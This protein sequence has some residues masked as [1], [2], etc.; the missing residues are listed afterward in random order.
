MNVKQ[1]PLRKPFSTVELT[2]GAG[3]CFSTAEKQVF[4]A[5]DYKLRHTPSEKE[6]L[7]ILENFHKV[8]REVEKLCSTPR[9]NMGS[10][11]GMSIYIAAANLFQQHIAVLLLEGEAEKRWKEL[12]KAVF[13][14]AGQ[15]VYLDQGRGTFVTKMY[16]S[17]V[18]LEM[19]L[20]PGDTFT[21]NGRHYAIVTTD[22]PFAFNTDHSTT[23][24]TELKGKTLEIRQKLQ[25][26]YPAKWELKGS[27]FLYHH[28]EG[29]GEILL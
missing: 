4:R 28:K 24:L 18:T 27:K 5:L 15:K 22:I 9:D 7:K 13:V 29:N 3:N 11:S 25:F 6:R 12:E 14:V 20:V 16:N 2:A 19:M 8:S 23:Y 10:L 26:P 17:K 1:P 21:C